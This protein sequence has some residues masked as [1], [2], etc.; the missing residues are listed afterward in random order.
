MTVAAS[1]VGLGNIWRFPYLAAKYGGGIFLLVYIIACLT[2]G[3]TMVIAETAIGRKTGTSAINAYRSIN[4]KCG[5]IGVLAAIVP[6]LIAPYY[7]VIG[8]WVIKYA[9][10]F[11]TGHVEETAADG[12]FG[13]FVG[14]TVSPIVFF[15]IFA[16]FVLLVV[17]LGVEKGVEKSSKICMPVLLVLSVVVAIYSL[18]LPN[19]LEGAKYYLLPDV[20]Q[21]SVMTFCTA[22]GQMFYS[23]SVAMGI[24]ITYGSY[25]SKDIDMEKSVKQIEIFDLGIA[26]IAGFMIIP[27][28]FSFS[29]GDLSMLK[30]GPSL[31]FIILPKVFASMPFGRVIGSVFFVLVIFAALTS[32]ISIAEAVTSNIMDTFRLTRKKALIGTTAIIV[33]LGIPVSLGFGVLDFIAPLGMDLLTFFDFLTGSLLMPLTAL[34]SCLFIGY[35]VGT[36]F[37]SDEV[38]I[39][40]EFKREKMFNVMIKYI[41]PLLLVIILVSYTL[42]AFGIISM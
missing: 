3:F 26:I 28:V 17:K 12:Y 31:M 5:I 36:K 40:S 4:K 20:S 37:V 2:F 21:F 24:L 13:E 25:M 6:A 8:G 14:S 27:A 41:A 10:M 32:A 1:A 15:F 35:V 19:A 42:D 11:I 7:C 33:I 30:A 23:L 22:V 38:K 16:F 39:S 9:F 18:T 34:L 29:Q